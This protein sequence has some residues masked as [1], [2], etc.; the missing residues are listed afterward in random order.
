MGLDNDPAT[1]RPECFFFQFQDRP[2]PP[3]RPSPQEHTGLIVAVAFSPDCFSVCSASAD[4]LLMIWD[5]RTGKRKYTLSGHAG[6]VLSCAYSADNLRIVSNDEKTVC[7]WNARDGKL[8]HMWGMDGRVPSRTTALPMDG[9]RP[10]MKYILSAFVPGPHIVTSINNKVVQVLNPN[11]GEEILSF[12]T[13]V[14]LSPRSGPCR[15]LARKAA[16]RATSVRQGHRVSRRISPVPV[17]HSVRPALGTS[18]TR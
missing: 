16:R 8:L 5:T 13:K 4:R 12:F 15:P 3:P 18:D 7:V 10:D 1:G 11:T 9:T 2:A 17:C 6:V 14:P